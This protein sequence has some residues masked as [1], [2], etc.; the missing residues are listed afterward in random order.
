VHAGRGTLIY[1]IGF[2][3]TDQAGKHDWQR[4]DLEPSPPARRA[5]F[6]EPNF[7]SLSALILC[8]MKGAAASSVLINDTASTE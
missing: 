3:A 4:S 1:C 5:L 8:K 7:K 2:G 6:H